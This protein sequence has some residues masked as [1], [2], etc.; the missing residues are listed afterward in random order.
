MEIQDKKTLSQMKQTAWSITMWMTDKT[1]YTPETINE[2]VQNMPNDWSLEGQIEQGKTSQTDLHYQLLL[3]TPQTRGTRIAKFFP[4]CH[5]EDARKFH[6]LKNYVHKADTRVAEFKTVENRSPQWSVVCDRFFD[7]VLVEQPE[8]GFF[9][10]V[11]EERMRLWDRFIGLSIQEGMRV[12][13]IG[14][15]PQYRSCIM[16]YW[17]DY[18]ELAKTRAPVDK[19]DR[20]TNRQK[21]VAEGGGGSIVQIPENVAPHRIRRVLK[22]LLPPE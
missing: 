1:G 2:F 17:S 4:K 20:Q 18:I 15:N 11:D 10:V 3:K 6:A 16:R 19:L 8:M 14:V 22:A 12:D 21:D 13:V 7:W 9:G 5:I